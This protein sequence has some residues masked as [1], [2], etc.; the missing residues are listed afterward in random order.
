MTGRGIPP[1]PSGGGGIRWVVGSHT[2]ESVLC[3]I[4]KLNCQLSKAAG[5]IDARLMPE[6]A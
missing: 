6:G 5:L 2:N 4:G 1:V 3:A